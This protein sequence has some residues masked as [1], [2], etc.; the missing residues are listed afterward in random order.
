MAK[1]FSVASWNVE[2]FNGKPERI[3]DVAAFLKSQSPDLFAISEVAGSEVYSGMVDA[4]PGY[5]FHITEGDQTQEL[6]V[7]IKSNVTAFITQRVEFKSRDTYMRPGVLVSVH[8]DDTNYS[9]LFLH[10]ASGSHPRGMGLRDD[11]LERAVLFRKNLDKAYG[12]KNKANY[13]FLGD[14]NVMGLSYP[15]GNDI[16]PEDEIRRWKTRAS[17]YYGMQLLEKTHDVTW[18]NGTGSSYPDAN[19]DHVFA[20]KHLQFKMFNGKPVAVRGW[21]NET[22]PEGKDKWIEKY[23]DHS[24]VYFEVQ[25]V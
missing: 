8:K 15:Y 21:V 7:G 6:L 19:L 23:S 16:S 14:L 1:A 17:R 5:S 3:A 11:M 2:H 20:A 4:F 22:T 18:S 24:L 25:K 12:G 13:I 10:L 9:V